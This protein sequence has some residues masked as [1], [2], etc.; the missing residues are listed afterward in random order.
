MKYIFLSS[1][2]LLKAFAGFA[3][4][5][6]AD[7]TAQ[8]IS[9]WDKGDKQSYTIT[10]EKIKIKG[11][12]TTSKEMTKYDVE[13]TV[14]NA[15]EKSYTVEWLYKNVSTNSKDFATQKLIGMSN[16]TKV[17]YKTDEMGV[18]EEILNWKE[19]KDF[20]LSATATLKK[21]YSHMDGMDKVIKQVESTYTT[22]DAIQAAVAKEIQQFHTF[23]GA[24]YTLG[25]LLEGQI[26]VP[27]IYGTEPFDSRFTVY[28]DE[29]N[30][31]DNNYIMRSTQE[32]NKEQLTNATYEYL[33]KMAKSLKVE[34]PKKSELMEL[35][36]ESLTS[37]RIHGTGWVIYSIQT[38]TV[39]AEESTQINERI[40]EIK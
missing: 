23:H 26:K 20:I 37:S 31:E 1:I 36:N 17:I 18:F 7:S 16:N 27:N 22:K 8:V 2:F 13:I 6:M 5:N 3:Q 35:K 28:L 14:I 12:D 11:S 29:I 10:E 21:E 33:T 30:E 19:L 32:I 25:E 38:I 34:I 9:Y 15:D 39:A 40:I 24:K 4:I